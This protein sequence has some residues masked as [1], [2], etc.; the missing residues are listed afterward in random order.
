MDTVS[1]RFPQPRAEATCVSPWS[2]FPQTVCV[3]ELSPEEVEALRRDQG[4]SRRAGGLCVSV[5]MPPCCSNGNYHEGAPTPCTSPA[6]TPECPYTCPV[7]ACV[8]WPWHVL[9]ALPGP[10][11]SPASLLLEQS[12]RNWGSC[13]PPVPWSS[14]GPAFH[15]PTVPGSTQPSVP[16]RAQPPEENLVIELASADEWHR[17]CSNARTPNSVSISHVPLHTL[18]RG[19]R[20]RDLAASLAAFQLFFFFFQPHYIQHQHSLMVAHM[21]WTGLSPMGTDLSQSA[22]GA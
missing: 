1:Q 11:S 15:T 14:S 8:P 17:H 7:W 5:A 3:P 12:G 4:Q 21:E 13:Q 18:P 9:Y 19:G 2:L 10:C 22:E 6:C 20:L 16:S